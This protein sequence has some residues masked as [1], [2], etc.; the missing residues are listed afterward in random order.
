MTQV[1]LSL[2]RALV[3]AGVGLSGCLSSDPPQDYGDP[4]SLSE[5]TTQSG[6]TVQILRPAPS[7]VP[8]APSVSIELAAFTE[9]AGPMEVLVFTR[10]GTTYA[11]TGAGIPGPNQRFTVD[12]PLLHG[13]NTLD[14]RVRRI[15]T[16]QLRRIALQVTYPGDAPG[17]RFGFRDDRNGE[18]CGVALTNDVTGRDSV[19]VRGVVS[20]ADGSPV[21][22]TVDVDGVP[23]TATLNADG[24]TFDALLPISPDATH[25]VTVVATGAGGRKTTLARSVVQDSTPPVISAAL[26]DSSPNRTSATTAVIAGT[27]TD[28]N[29]IAALRLLS[30][31]GGTVALVPGAT[32]EHTVQLIS[33][34]NGFSIVAVDAAGNEASRPVVIVRDRLIRLGPPNPASTTTLNLDRAAIESLLDLT[35]QKETEV[36]QVP[37][38]TAV[39]TT[40]YSI[41]DPE[42]FGLD[43]SG[44]GQA[45]WN[46]HTLL[47]M[48]PDNANL[49]GSSIEELLDIAPA[50]G[51]PSPRLLANLLDI[52][53]TDTFLILEAAAD[54]VL[55]QLIATHPNICGGPSTTPGACLT[56]DAMGNPLLTLTMWDVLN[57]LTTANGRFGPSGTH[58][59][60]VEG[61]LYSSVLEPG[62]LMSIPASS[63]LDPY[64]GVD[65]SRGGKEYFF[66]QRPGTNSALVLDFLSPDF[67]VVGL[68]DEPVVDI[69][70]IV[71]ES[72]SFFTV[73]TSPAGK[74]ARPDANAPGFY[75]GNSP[76]W[77]TNPWDLERIVSEAAY[78]QYRVKFA[79]SSYARTLRYDA[80]SIDDAAVLDWSRGWVT[81][82]TSGGIGNPPPPT[83][84]W[85][86]L[87]EVAQLRLHEGGIAEGAADVA[88][89]LDDLAIGLDANGLV[90]ALRPTLSAQAEELANRLIDP[91][92]LIASTADFYFVPSSTGGPGFLFFR[93]ASDS[94]GTY[95]YA[96]PGF[97]SNS[98]LATK[99]STMGAMTGTNDTAHEKVVPVVGAKFYFAD[100]TSAVYELEVVTVDSAGVEVRVAPIVGGTP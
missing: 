100:D 17:L 30:D 2:F 71:G 85:D 70:F 50:V 38:R 26:A 57:D 37:L 74:T 35:A 14:I 4:T 45:E 52:A 66:I 75:R 31:A 51:L 43:T 8:S 7:T 92:G 69:R 53:P 86:I 13:S 34:T 88:F 83:F 81:I 11:A 5:S 46:L 99:V 28:S 60:F 36:V 94:T 84:V 93:S 1:R 98:T 29:G 6:I 40:L 91:D 25:E 67:S 3:V 9:P 24:R 54:V 20:S 21:T 72:N 96:T 65:A 79:S 77:N 64:Q 95:S 15:G 78:Q 76:V 42:L 18:P 59:G 23:G 63:N 39:L 33:G 58:P 80:G 90:D 55:K 16:T 87:D 44:W 32:F 47:N 82:T 49:Q 68:V 41:R 22:L 27:V 10:E 61:S 19:C 97:F 56:I 89:N 62:F 12:V 73:S 48:T